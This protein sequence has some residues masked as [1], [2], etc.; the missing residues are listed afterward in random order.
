MC[1][2]DKDVKQD[3]FKGFESGYDGKF[4]YVS[5]LPV[6]FNK[7]GSKLFAQKAQNMFNK[8]LN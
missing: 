8:K 1:G 5:T 7:K 2:K 4:Y 3:L 6:F